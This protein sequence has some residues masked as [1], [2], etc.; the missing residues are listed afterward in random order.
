MR[1]PTGTLGTKLA[2]DCTTICRLCT[3]TR[4]DSTVIRITDHDV[5]V[6]YGGDT[7]VSDVGF[8]SS[9][10]LSAVRS[11]LQ[12]VT[13]TLA[14]QDDSGRV[15]LGDI[16]G[17][18]YDEAQCQLIIV[19]YTNPDDG[20]MFLFG[21][22]VRSVEVDN[23]QR[24]QI[25]IAGLLTADRDIE[26]E[27]YSSTC[28][29]DLGDSRCTFDIDSLK[30]TYTVTAVN[31]RASFET[32][33]LN[34]DDEFWTLGVLHWLT[35]NNAGIAMEVRK[36]TKSDKSLQ[37]WLPSPFSVQVGDTGEVWP[38]CDKSLSTCRDTY[39]NAVNFRGE[40][41]LGAD[42]TSQGPA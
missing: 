4:K 40:P 39:D 14:A 11:G 9:S 16:N 15:S 2:A 17:G 6:V 8:T 36:S 1:T 33:E 28:R 18:A 26:I 30:E 13:L 27:Y 25:E 21:G 10:V 20:H 23:E 38:G 12:G 32:S 5:D 24:L 34:Q 35:G 42:E 29:A 22:E 19:D 3:I 7:F 37:T 31:S 41:Y